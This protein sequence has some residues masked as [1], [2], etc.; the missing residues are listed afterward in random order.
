MK[1]YLQACIVLLQ[2]G[3]E[4]NMKDEQGD[5]P[6]HLAAYEGHLEATR[7]LLQNSVKKNIG[8]KGGFSPLHYAAQEGHRELTGHLT[9][10]G[11]YQQE[12]YAELW[13]S[14]I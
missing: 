2:H 1:P 9:A 10:K 3:V 11:A 13:F 14:I 8:D 5:T 4:K 6:L 12:A 7:I